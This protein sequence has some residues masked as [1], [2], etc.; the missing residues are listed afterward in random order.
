ME[1]MSS[2]HT[3]IPG[4]R[5]VPKAAAGVWDGQEVSVEAIALV[6]TID[7]MLPPRR[8]GQARHARAPAH[9][10]RYF[11]PV[12]HLPRGIERLIPSS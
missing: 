12:S 7:M 3:L 11:P 10:W 5:N 6:S 2:L 1:Y 4:R 8:V 9:H